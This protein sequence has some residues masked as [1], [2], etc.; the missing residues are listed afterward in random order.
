MYACVCVFLLKV[1]HR[2]A[3]FTEVWIAQNNVCVCL[4]LL[5]VESNAPHCCVHEG[6][7]STK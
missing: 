1:M 6:V 3:V 7:D 4:C 5:P 2:T